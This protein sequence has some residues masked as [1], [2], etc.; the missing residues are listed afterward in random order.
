MK[1]SRSRSS[2]SLYTDSDGG[3]VVVVMLD[4][5]TSALDATGR[6]YSIGDIAAMGGAGTASTG[7][8]GAEA[9]GSSVTIAVFGLERDEDFE[10]FLL[11]VVTGA[12]GTSDGEFRGN[13]GSGIRGSSTGA[14]FTDITGLPGTGV[15]EAVVV[16][17]I[18]SR[19][20]LA[21][22][23]SVNEEG[24]SSNSKE[25]LGLPFSRY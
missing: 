7:G 15:D 19:L 16:G 6:T 9:T 8:G 11:L 22:S 23:E 4:G 13:I 12:T 21:T 14:G 17:L 1:I 2:I 10:D 5:I 18:L 25:T 20:T 24:I 3:G